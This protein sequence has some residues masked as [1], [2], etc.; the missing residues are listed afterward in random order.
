MLVPLSELCWQEQAAALTAQKKTKELLQQT[1]AMNNALEQIEPISE[2]PRTPDTSGLALSTQI[3]I[4]ISA[5]CER[6]RESYLIGLF[7]TSLSGVP[8]ITR[9][10]FHKHNNEHVF[11]PNGKFFYDEIIIFNSP[12]FAYGRGLTAS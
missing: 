2:M 8:Y 4:N 5:D 11:D 3:T 6:I 1:E 9:V 10:I 7:T 12:L